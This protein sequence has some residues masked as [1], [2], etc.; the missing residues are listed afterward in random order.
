MASHDFLAPTPMKEN[1]KRRP[2]VLT[3]AT[4]LLETGAGRA[5]SV[6]PAAANRS[7]LRIT[8]NRTAQNALLSLDMRNPKYHGVG[9]K[10][11]L[12]G[13]LWREVSCQADMQ[14]G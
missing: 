11:N 12:I 14:D 9:L 8:R 1:N 7:P 13:I 6:G 4:A 10:E 2:R 3:V 5:G